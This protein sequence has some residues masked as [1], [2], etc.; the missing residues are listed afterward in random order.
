MLCRKIYKNF[1]VISLD[2][3]IGQA[4]NLLDAPRITIQILGPSNA[5]RKSSKKNQSVL[6]SSMSNPAVLNERTD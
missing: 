1:S 4:G 3:P 2:R 6:P 5:F